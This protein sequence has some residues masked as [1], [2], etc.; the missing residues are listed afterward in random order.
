ME[1]SRILVTIL[2]NLIEWAL[3]RNTFDLG[4]H[5]NYMI[6]QNNENLFRDDMPFK[7]YL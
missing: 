7:S 5:L 1:K 2:L 4:L 3:A 6:K